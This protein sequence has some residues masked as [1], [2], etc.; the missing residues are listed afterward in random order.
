MTPPSLFMRRVC[1]VYAINT[2]CRTTCKTAKDYGLSLSS[3]ANVINHVEFRVNRAVLCCHPL[4]KRT[5]YM[6]RERPS[7]QNVHVS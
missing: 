7:A 2:L 1:S 5:L 6:H 4:A 3:M